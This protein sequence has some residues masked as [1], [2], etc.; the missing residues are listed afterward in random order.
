[1]E[2]LVNYYILLFN[3]ELIRMNKIIYHVTANNYAMDNK[4]TVNIRIVK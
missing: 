4:L 2:F 3:L 1:M